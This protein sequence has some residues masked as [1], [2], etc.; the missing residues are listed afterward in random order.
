MITFHY[1][2]VLHSTF[3]N[4]TSVL[5]AS[6]FDV[7]LFYAT[8]CHKTLF[9]NQIPLVN[10]KFSA[11]HDNRKYSNLLRN[12]YNKSECCR[13]LLKIKLIVVLVVLWQKREFVI[14]NCRKNTSLKI[15]NKLFCLVIYSLISSILLF[16]SRSELIFVSGTLE[17]LSEADGMLSLYF[18]MVY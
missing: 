4:D 7:S 14:E 12:L 6:N 18:I 16:K 13:C 3:Y 11:F 17:K 9:Q 8:A 2:I 5:T 1:K 15:A 10:S